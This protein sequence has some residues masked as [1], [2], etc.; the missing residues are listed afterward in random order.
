MVEMFE[1]LKEWQEGR[2][3]VNRVYDMVKNEPFCRDFALRDQIVKVAISVPSNIAEGFERDSDRE[4]IRFLYISKG[5]AGEVRSQLHHALDQKYV[6]ESMFGDVKNFC[7]ELSKKLGNF[8][9]YLESSGS[10]KN[11]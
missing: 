10:K 6:S 2:E 5:S 3:L 4:F 1:D 9:D 8:I 7:F 11:R